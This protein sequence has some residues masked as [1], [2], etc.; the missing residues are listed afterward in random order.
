MGK[1]ILVK[2]EMLVFKLD[3]NLIE[4]LEIDLTI[5]VVV[6]MNDLFPFNQFQD[7]IDISVIS[8]RKP[9]DKEKKLCYEH[10]EKTGLIS[11]LLNNN[12]TWEKNYQMPVN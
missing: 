5:E 4:D 12:K 9:T 2:N 6:F 7:L 1:Y 8:F 11:L 10:F 3:K